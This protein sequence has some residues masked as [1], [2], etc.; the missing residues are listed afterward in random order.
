MPLGTCT[1]LQTRQ[2]TLDLLNLKLVCTELC[3]A[4]DPCKTTADV[5]FHTVVL[6]VPVVHSSSFSA[7]LTERPPPAAGSQCAAGHSSEAELEEVEEGTK[8]WAFLSES[9]GQELAS[10]SLSQSHSA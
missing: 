8:S 10:G 9:V 4:G 3:H 5:L 1:I 2:V 6:C 7:S